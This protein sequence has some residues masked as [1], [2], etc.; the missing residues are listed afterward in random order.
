MVEIELA[1]E[2]LVTLLNEIQDRIKGKPW[3]SLNRNG[4]SYAASNAITELEEALQFIESIEEEHERQNLP[5]SPSSKE[6]A[7]GCKDAIV[8]LKKNKLFEQKKNENAIPLLFEMKDSIAE[9]ELYSHL[10]QKIL[11]F[12]LKARYWVDRVVIYEK[13]RKLKPLEGRSARKNVLDLLEQKENELEELRKRY[14]DLRV[15]THLGLIEEKTVADLEKEYY[16][17]VRK[18]DS[19]LKLIISQVSLFEKDI[20]NLAGKYKMIKAGLSRAEELS[21]KHIESSSELITCL[22]KERDYAK[23][24]VM[25]IENET[26]RL[27]SAYSKEL[28]SLEEEKEIAK[29]EAYEKFRQ[30]LL[31]ARQEIEHRD[32]AI[33]DFREVL[34]AREEKNA[35]L[36]KKLADLE[37]E[38]RLLGEKLADVDGGKK[39]RGN[40]PKNQ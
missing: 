22:K 7:A 34:K 12:V 17:E 31:K 19:E 20:E 36:S 33:K 38:N 35:F 14:S 23:R 32:S 4:F 24:I 28:L 9:K 16:G 6:L 13:K 1:A 27:R 39:K 2:K 3:K 8:N 18:E 29:H 30:Q 21:S 37:R 5:D 10:E 40:K 15:K 26:V 11:D 25:E